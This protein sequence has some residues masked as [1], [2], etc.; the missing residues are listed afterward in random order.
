MK[1]YLAQPDFRRDVAVLLKGQTSRRD[2]WVSDW[3]HTA[4]LIIDMQQYFLDPRS[5]ACVPGPGELIVK[6]RALRA[7]CRERRLPVV[8]TRHSNT[9]ADAGLLADWWADLVRPEDPLSRITS[10]LDTRGGTVIKKTQYDAFFHTSLA[11][12]LRRRRVRRLIVCGVVTHLC[13]ETT[14]RSAFVRGFDVLLPVDAT[15][16]YSPDF[17]LA[18]LRNLAHGF[19]LLTTVDALV[20]DLRTERRR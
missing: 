12:V 15:G 14:V 2:R 6:V 17:H 10:E 9:R 18:S 5:H 13:C 11:T 1:S 8:F 3:T 19:A 16:T 4:L 20:G 7:A